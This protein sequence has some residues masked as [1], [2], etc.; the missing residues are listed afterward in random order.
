MY[1]GHETLVLGGVFRKL[2]LLAQV[3]IDPDDL[4]VADRAHVNGPQSSQPMLPCLRRRLPPDSP[5][6]HLHGVDEE[7]DLLRGELLVNLAHV[8]P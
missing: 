3:H 2:V 6:A 1:R 7:L 8:A 4:F 5:P